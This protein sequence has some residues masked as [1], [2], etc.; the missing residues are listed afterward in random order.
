MAM[1]SAVTFR[2]PGNATSQQNLFALLN[3]G[4]AVVVR[5]RRLI[6]QID[7]TGALIALMPMIKLCRIT[8]YGGGQAITKVNW[9]ATASNAQVQARGRNTSDGGAQTDITATLGETIWQQYG[10]RNASAAGE[11]I[12]EDQNIAPL[13]IDTDPIVLRANEGILVYVEAM[14]STSNPTTTHY[15]VECAWDEA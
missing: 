7:S 11:S 13:A 5:V 2:T 14:A 1:M 9:E 10:S 15:M 4:T 12:C 8:A 6:A 3:T